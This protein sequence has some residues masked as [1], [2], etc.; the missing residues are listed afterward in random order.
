V[1]EIGTLG[2]MSGDGKRSAGHRPQAT[3]PILDST[4]TVLVVGIGCSAG[5]LKRPV[6]PVRGFA[7]HLELVD[8]IERRGILEFHSSTPRFRQHCAQRALGQ[9]QL[10]RV[11]MGRLGIGE[12][13]GRHSLG[14]KR[15]R[16]FG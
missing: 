10:E 8:R 1:P 13:S 7:H 4:N 5:R 12:Q 11:L 2:L 14:T 9:L 15:Q 6:N 3:A 16:G